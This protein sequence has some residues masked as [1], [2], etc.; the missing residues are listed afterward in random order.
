MVEE[1]QL[2]SLNLQDHRE[3][4]VRHQSIQIVSDL[5]GQT[6]L[7]KDIQEVAILNLH[8]P[9]CVHAILLRLSLKL[10]TVQGVKMET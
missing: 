10:E 3:S 1:Y 7:L 6:L 5:T 2:I 4:E 9:D 8:Q